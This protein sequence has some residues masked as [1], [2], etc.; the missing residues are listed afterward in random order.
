MGGMELTLVRYHEKNKQKLK[1]WLTDNNNN[2]KSPG[3]KTTT[4]T[5]GVATAMRKQKSRKS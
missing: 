4:T 2:S 1:R 5:T 3:A